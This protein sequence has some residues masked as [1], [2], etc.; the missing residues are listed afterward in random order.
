MITL[1]IRKP[2]NYKEPGAVD[3]S[4]YGW[5]INIE[6]TFDTLEAAYN[7]IV[8]EYKK[9]RF[10][11]YPWHR[12]AFIEGVRAN[13]ENGSVAIGGKPES[14]DAFKIAVLMNKLLRNDREAG[15]KLKAAEIT[16]MNTEAR[17]FL[18][19]DITYMD[20]VAERGKKV[21]R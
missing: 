12:P 2:I 8:A 20:G 10:I 16:S 19:K 5:W 18:K 6:Q 17:A 4:P 11:L 1:T 3:Y 7:F 13:Q 21:W 14:Q 15:R 9:D